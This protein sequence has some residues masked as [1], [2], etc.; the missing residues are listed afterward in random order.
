MI[1][2][3]IFMNFLLVQLMVILA[4][5]GEKIKGF[6]LAGFI[7]VLPPIAFSVII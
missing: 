5:I 4:F 3:S 1:Y 7:M 2:F 6:S